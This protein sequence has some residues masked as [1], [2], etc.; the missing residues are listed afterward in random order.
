MELLPSSRQPK[1]RNFEMSSGTEVTLFHSISNVQ[2]L[3]S[4]ELISFCHAAMAYLNRQ[5]GTSVNWFSD[6]HR[7]ISPVMSPNSSGS[8]S[9]LLLLRLTVSNFGLQ[10]SG[11]TYSISLHRAHSDLMLGQL[12]TSGSF[13]ILFLDMSSHS[14]FWKPSDGKSSS[15]F[16][17]RSTSIN[18]GHLP[19]ALGTDEIWLLSKLSRSRWAILPIELGI[20]LILLQVSFKQGIYDL[21]DHEC[22]I[23]VSY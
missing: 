7:D 11:C 10:N 2:S 18:L 23:L 6:N 17:E 8:L 21:F 1:F 5:L 3:R 14:S 16:L 22:F 19:R 20:A 9:S 13:R 4:L 12:T 15:L